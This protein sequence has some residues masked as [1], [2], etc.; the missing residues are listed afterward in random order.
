MSD[1]SD[2]EFQVEIE[3]KSMPIAPA[4]DSSHEVKSYWIYRM[5][6]FPGHSFNCSSDAFQCLFKSTLETFSKST[7]DEG[8]AKAVEHLVETLIVL[9]LNSYDSDD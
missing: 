6:C 9:S 1:D 2:D 5:L 7:A 3:Q 8:Y 4:E